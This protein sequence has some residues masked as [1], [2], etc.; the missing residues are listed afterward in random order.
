MNISA[1]H[2]FNGTYNKVLYCHRTS[3]KLRWHSF[4]FSKVKIWSTVTFMID[5]KSPR[6]PSNVIC[7]I[8]SLTAPIVAVHIS[9]CVDGTLLL[10]D[11]PDGAG[12]GTG[13]GS[14]LP[15]TLT[16]KLLQKFISLRTTYTP[17]SSTLAVDHSRPRTQ[18]PATSFT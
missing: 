10:L 15:T 7:I 16:F 8:S 2:S 17:N 4:H 18:T 13:D 1:F 14:L 9:Y 3:T 12:D 5:I 11:N 6:Q